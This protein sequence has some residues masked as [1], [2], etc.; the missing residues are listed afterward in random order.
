MYDFDYQR[1]KMITFLTME[2]EKRKHQPG[3]EIC[4]SIG[5][6]AIGGLSAAGAIILVEIE[7][8]TGSVVAA[9]PALVSLVAT[10]TSMIAWENVF[11]QSNNAPE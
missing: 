1:Q 5:L 4:K 9:F 7:P 3:L 11:G 2:E 8:I 6:A 10:V